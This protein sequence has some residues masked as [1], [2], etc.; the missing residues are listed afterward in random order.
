MHDSICGGVDIGPQRS[1]LE[2][3]DSLDMI[4]KKTKKDVKAI[5]KANASLTQELKECISNLEET[6]RTHRESNST[7]DRCLI[8]LQ[9]KEIE[10][11]KYKTYLNRTT[12]YDTLE[13]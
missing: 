10:L 6:N 5:K 9:N 8:T 13:R 2:L 1:L 4:L 11:E 12:E 7:R 3:M